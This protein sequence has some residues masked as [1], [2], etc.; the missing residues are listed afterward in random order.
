M[1]KLNDYNDIVGKTF[2]SWL[3]TGYA[4][5][6][7]H[8]L[9]YH[10]RCECGTEKDVYRYNLLRGATVSCGCIKERDIT[11]TRFNDLT[12]KVFGRLT[13]LGVA[14]KKNSYYFYHCRCECG[15]EVIV[16]GVALTKK[17]NSTKSCGCLHKKVNRR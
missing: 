7:G 4:G 5:K 9:Y 13:V 15:K 14:Y 12:G 16:R 17:K 8:A 11:T 6:K 3:V 1:R 10:C 2:G